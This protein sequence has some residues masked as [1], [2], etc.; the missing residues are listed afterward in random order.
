MLTSGSSVVHDRVARG[1]SKSNASFGRRSSASQIHDS[2]TSL[3]GRRAFGLHQDRSVAV[4][5]F[6]NGAAAQLMPCGLPEHGRGTHGESSC[7]VITFAQL[8]YQRSLK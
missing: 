4:R 5:L 7:V 3:S 6:P 2:S 1:T 8:G